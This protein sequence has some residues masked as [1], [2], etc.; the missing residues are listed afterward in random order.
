MKSRFSLFFVLVLITQSLAQFDTLKSPWPVTPLNSSHGI[1]GNFSEFRNTGSSDHFHNA[2]DIGKEDYEPCYPVFDGE[3]YSIDTGSSNAYV[4]IVTNIN[5]KWKHITYLH[6]DPNPALEVG[7]PVQKGVT[8]LG[9][10]YPGM[11]HV[12]LG[13]R[14]LVSD[15]NSSGAYINNIRKNGPTC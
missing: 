7:D 2:V 8:E 10:I 11:G 1:N 12:H 13:E 4:R 14:E 6:I 9:T 5:G 3:V 15:K